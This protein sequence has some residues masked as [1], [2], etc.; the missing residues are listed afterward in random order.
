MICLWFYGERHISVHKDP[1]KRVYFA[2]ALVDGPH[3]Y[4]CVPVDVVKRHTNA[5]Q[6]VYELVQFVV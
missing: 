2:H 1:S 4:P 6:H 5:S 3:G